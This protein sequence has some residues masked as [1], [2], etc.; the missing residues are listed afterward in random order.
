MRVF[1]KILFAILSFVTCSLSVSSLSSCSNTKSYADYVIDE[2]NYIQRWLD[3][4]NF[5]VAATFDEEQLDKMAT[6]ILEDSAVPSDYIELG[7]WYQVG[8]G[9]FKRLLFR[10]NDWGKGYPDMKSKNK[11]YED[12][13]VL[14][15]Y[16]SLFD[17]S[18][19]DYT[20]GAKN[21][22]ADNLEPNSYQICY[23]WRRNYYSNTYY[24]YSYSSGSSYDCTSGGL[25]FPIRFLWQGGS[26]S[27]ICPFNLIPSSLSSYY[28]TLYY[29]TIRY[30]KPNYTPQ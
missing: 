24:S 10:V 11:F 21:Y 8:E 4:K 20:E 6:K 5:S 9:D 17:I 19:Y 1:K 29:G 2:E 25:G 28:Y 27:V 30:T 18:G 13:N 26:A 12:E 7:K 14:V 23:N 22:S 15:R 3:Y 16:D